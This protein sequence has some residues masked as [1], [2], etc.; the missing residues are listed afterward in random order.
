MYNVPKDKLE[1]LLVVLL[2]YADF[3][4]HQGPLQ[5][6]DHTDNTKI[7]FLIENCPYNMYLTY[8]HALGV[9]I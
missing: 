4:V 8:I 2:G 7:G 3:A 9:L 6:L 1:L 5:A